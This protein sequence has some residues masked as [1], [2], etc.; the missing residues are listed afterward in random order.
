MDILISSSDNILKLVRKH[1]EL[2][3]SFEYVYLF[4]S[5]LKLENHYKDIDILAIYIKYSERI[6]K[7]ILKISDEIEKA[8][9]LPVDL[10][11]LSVEEER[12]TD[13][14]EKI[15]PYCLRIK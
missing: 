15:K 5:V 7:D 2:F 1:I 13:F 12:E 14:L 4:G 10:T 9:G 8:S 6:G 11:V 3:V